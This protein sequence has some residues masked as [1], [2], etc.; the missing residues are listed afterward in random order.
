[1]REI[2]DGK[3]RVILLSLGFLALGFRPEASLAADPSKYVR[4]A[5]YYLKA[6]IGIPFSDYEKLARYDVIVLPAEAQVFN[7]DLFPE[8]RRRNPDIIILAYVPTKSYAMVWNDSL[9]DVLKNDIAGHDE[10]RLKTPDGNPLSVWPNTFA[11]NI[12]SGYADYLAR[13]TAEK[14]L[15][16]GLWDGVFYDEASATISWLNGGNLD[17][18]RDGNRDSASE[19]DR[20]WKDGMLRLVRT[21]RELAGPTKAIVMNGDNDADIAKST[22]GR[23]FETFPTPWEG[24][25]SWQTVEGAYLR[26]QKQVGYEPL[27]IINGNSGNTGNRTEYAKVR[28]GL[29]SA[30]M[31]DGYFG[32]DFGDQDHGQ[33]WEFD[34][35]NAFLGRPLS[36]ARN[37]SGST[38]PV[39]AGLWRRDFEN[40]VVLV[41]SSDKTLAVDFD[42]D[43]ER[44]HGTQDPGVNNGQISNYVEVPS[45]DGLILLRPLDRVSGTS[46]RN[47]TFLRI[48]DG[49]GSAKRTGF[50]AYNK[51]H[52]G[53]TILAEF[54]SPDYGAGVVLSAKGNRLELS[55]AEGVVL[56]TVY[57]FGEGWKANVGFSIGTFG[58]RTYV[59][60]AGGGGAAPR[61][62]AYDGNLNPISETW[63]AYS[64][65][66][67]G[68]VNVAIGDIDNDGEADI[69]TGAGPG[70]GP[71]VRVFNLLGAVKAQFFAYD[72]KMKNGVTVGLGDTDG[73]GQTEIVTGTGFGGVPQVRVWSRTGAKIREFYA[74][75]SKKRGGVRVSV[76][77]VDGDGR[78]EILAMS[79]DVFTLAYAR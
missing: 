64:P 44:L 67:L 14:I 13:F 30:L 1:M 66:F 7:Q 36:A 60:A 21:T 40:G 38:E 71:H 28:F 23:M 49:N 50:F 45:R 3:L 58:G 78:Y 11:L 51:T 27:F 22:N 41:N 53:G 75:D 74:F 52:R 55:S 31:G 15:A 10:W 56:K 79:N 65:K 32:Y 46:Y 77:D 72:Q 8:V 24:D 54:N 42:G 62:R 70:G 4:T 39:R 69:L 19:A 61:V 59:A 2:L 37:L 12:G 43:Y 63:D 16:T 25:G 20:L 76:H 6:G 57:P 35:Y 68:G 5:N 34:E 18:N 26:L 33:F 29:A 73:D 9:H 47:G 17:L 48:L